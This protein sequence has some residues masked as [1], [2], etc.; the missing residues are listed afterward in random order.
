MMRNEM[1]R[2]YRERVAGAAEGR[3]LEIGVGSR[4]KFRFYRQS[5]G[6]LVALEPDP[7]PGWRIC[8]PSRPDGR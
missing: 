5:A 3:V 1:M 6:E 7:E 4:L 8:E 2:P